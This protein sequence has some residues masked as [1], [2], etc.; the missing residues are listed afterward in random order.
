MTFDS[1]TRWDT[2]LVEKLVIDSVQ[3]ELEQPKLTHRKTIYIFGIAQSTS[4][5]R[6][7]NWLEGHRLMFVSDFRKLLYKDTPGTWDDQL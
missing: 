3:L 6:V 2:V 5:Y 1:E 4:D 7:K